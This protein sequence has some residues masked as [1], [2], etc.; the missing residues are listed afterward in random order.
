MRSFLS[1]WAEVRIAL[2]SNLTA[3]PAL[4]QLDLLVSEAE[5]LGRGDR[6]GRG[7]RSPASRPARVLAVPA[8]RVARDPAVCG[9]ERRLLP[10]LPAG[11]RRGL[12]TR[13]RRRGTDRA[14]QVVLLPDR[15]AARE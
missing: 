10:P 15:G 4:F 5:R 12:Q 6:A 13:R 1:K 3:S 8:A 9:Q 2:P 7:G 14:R 11:P